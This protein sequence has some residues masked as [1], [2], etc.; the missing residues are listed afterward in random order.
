MKVKNILITGIIAAL[1]MTSAAFADGGEVYVNGV[2]TTATV[3]D[4]SI[5]LRPVAEALGFDVEWDGSTKSIALTDLPRYVTMTVGIDGYT[6]A[7]TAPMPLGK[8][9]FIKDGTTYV[10]IE[11]FS[12]ILDY[13]TEVEI[14]KE[15][16][17][18]N[19]KAEVEAENV[20]I[21]DDNNTPVDEFENA[22][23]DNADEYKA[24]AKNAAVKEI[25]DNNILIEDEERGEV[26]LIVGEDTSI[27]DNEG[28]ALTIE[29]I[30]V[31]S[32]LDVEYGP[33][34]TMSIP[35]ITNPVSIIVVE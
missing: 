10:P 26:M 35:P 17:H 32:K 18:I 6:F 9:P 31:D 22:E 24:E 30:K 8:A 16:Y 4:N 21:I 19:E 3:S 11:L 20:I 12:D 28:N 5:A 2:K 1:T 23:T 33:A 34:M 14:N 25:D 27:T 29:D 7:R 13:E 15:I